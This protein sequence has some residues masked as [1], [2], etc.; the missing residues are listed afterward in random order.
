MVIEHMDELNASCSIAPF[1]PPYLK[2][3]AAAVTGCT[4]KAT[5]MA[6]GYQDYVRLT[7]DSVWSLVSA[8]ADSGAVASMRSVAQ[9]L[10]IRDIL[11][12]WA[13]RAGKG[14]L[15]RETLLRKGLIEERDF[16]L[17]D[18]KTHRR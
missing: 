16:H 1:V 15:L 11:P 5:L 17:L 6:E 12:Y 4:D 2:R 8:V 9:K 10:L 18:L 14:E 3:V 7:E 13:V